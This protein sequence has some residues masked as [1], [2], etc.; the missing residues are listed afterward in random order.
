[1]PTISSRSAKI[2]ANTLGT[3][4]ADELVAVLGQADDVAIE[5]DT[6]FRLDSVSAIQLACVLSRRTRSINLTLPETPSAGLRDSL[7]RSF[8]GPLMWGSASPHSLTLSSDDLSS[9]VTAYVDPERNLFCLSTSLLDSRT[10]EGFQSDLGKWMVAAKILI[11]ER[12]YQRI[13]AMTYEANANAEEHGSVRL[14]DSMGIDTRPVFKCFAARLHDEPGAALSSRARTYLREYLTHFAKRTRWLEIVVADAGMGL[15]FPRYALRAQAL[16]SPRQ[17]VYEDSFIAERGQFDEILAR[18]VSTK[19]FWGRAHS[20]SSA[21]GEGTT[22]IKRNIAQLRAFGE[23][24]AGRCSATVYYSGAATDEGRIRSLEYVSDSR[25]RPLFM[26]TAWHLLVPLD[27]Q[28]QM[29][30]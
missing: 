6:S 4:S 5:L 22:L 8:L 26:G 16:K 17:D 19:G 28:L 9:R 11:D 13:A 2:S 1:M 29:A 30:L 27:Q 25:E 10:R 7:A 21:I 23:V 24:R 20:T 12:I 14:S 15:T 3:K 18:K